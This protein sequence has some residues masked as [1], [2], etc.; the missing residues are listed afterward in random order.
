MAQCTG[1]PHDG[2]DNFTLAADPA[3]GPVKAYR[4]I[5]YAC[6]A[7]E[8]FDDGGTAFVVPCRIDG[9]YPPVA[10]WP[11]CRQVAACNATLPFPDNR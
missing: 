10:A 8:V 1:M 2:V 5:T 9:S 4:D 7:G 6:P 3:S 11:E